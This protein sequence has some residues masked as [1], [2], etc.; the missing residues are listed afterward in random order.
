MTDDHRAPERPSRLARSADTA[1]NIGAWTALPTMMVIG[2]LGGYFVGAWL[3]GRYGHAPWMSFGGLVLG[4]VASVRKVVQ[5][6]R[7][8]QRRQNQARQQNRASNPR[9]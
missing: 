2:L 4:G 1:K 3:E 7:A 6:V 8:E 9:F 5:T